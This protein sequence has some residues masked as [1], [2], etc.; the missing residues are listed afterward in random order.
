MKDPERFMNRA[1]KLT[2][3]GCLFAGCL[4]IVG[5]LFAAFVAWNAQRTGIVA[6]YAQYTML[7][8]YVPG[9]L[10]GMVSLVVGFGSAFVV[11]VLNWRELLK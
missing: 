9:I 6:P 7:T 1:G 8:W 4:L 3:V 11:L 10:V 2:T 5:V